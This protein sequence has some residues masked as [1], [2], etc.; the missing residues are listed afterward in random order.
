MPDLDFFTL[1]FFF[2][3]NKNFGISDK[4]EDDSV[5]SFEELL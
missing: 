5:P 3:P 4:I 2:R 1:Y